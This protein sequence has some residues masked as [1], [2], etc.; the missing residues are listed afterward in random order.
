MWGR[1]HSKTTMDLEEDCP[2]YDEG[3]VMALVLVLVLAL[4]LVLVMEDEVLALEGDVVQ[5]KEPW[6]NRNFGPCQEYLYW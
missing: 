4:V 5:E 2:C 6:T 3:M 1:T